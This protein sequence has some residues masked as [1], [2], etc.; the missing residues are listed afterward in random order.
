[1]VALT[2]LGNVSWR[3]GATIWVV[4]EIADSRP[5]ALIAIGRAPR[6]GD[7]LSRTQAQAD[8]TATGATPL[9]GQRN[10]VEKS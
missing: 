10:R 4:F 1:M 8:H 5:T 9:G 3:H 2:T 7:R 6:L